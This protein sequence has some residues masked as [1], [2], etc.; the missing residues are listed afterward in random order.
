MIYLPA[1]SMSEQPGR[2]V[3]GTPTERTG[4]RQP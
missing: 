3:G 4:G 2:E 1:E